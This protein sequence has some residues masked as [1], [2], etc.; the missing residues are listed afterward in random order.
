LNKFAD[1]LEL[2]SIVIGD[3]TYHQLS[4][5]LDEVIKWSTNWQ[6]PIATQ[7]C[8][9][10]HIGKLNCNYDY[11][12]FHS[13]L[14]SLTNVKDL[15]VMFSSD[16]KSTQHCTE[17]I[18]KAQQR[19][20]IIRRCFCSN[21]RD[22]LLWAYKVYVRPILEYASLVRSPYLLDDIDRIENVQRRFTKKVAWS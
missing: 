3:E 13:E 4:S 21:D 19:L 6:L 12:L 20:A 8:N 11:F 1:D 14:S 9:V 7:K 15:G 16:L 5:S 22:I 18:K 10:L 2:H 17:I